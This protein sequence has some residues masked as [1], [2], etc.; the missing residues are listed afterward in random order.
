MS[1][2]TNLIN[3]FVDMASDNS[4]ESSGQINFASLVDGTTDGGTELEIVSKITEPYNTY[5]CSLIP[6]IKLTLDDKHRCIGLSK[7]T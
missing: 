5:P 2:K 4:L 7:L 1:V 6:H 3:I